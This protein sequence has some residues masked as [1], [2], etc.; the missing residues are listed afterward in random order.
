MLTKYAMLISKHIYFYTSSLRFLKKKKSVL[1][2]KNIVLTQKISN[3]L[4]KTINLFI[5]KLILR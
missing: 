4:L 1:F 2:V 3:L 5:R